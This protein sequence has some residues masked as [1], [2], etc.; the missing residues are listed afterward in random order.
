MSTKESYNIKYD[1]I[2][3]EWKY[4][5][6]HMTHEKVE[7]RMLSLSTKKARCDVGAFVAAPPKQS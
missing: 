6:D 7:T 5:N 2:E 3:N 4:Y 1:E